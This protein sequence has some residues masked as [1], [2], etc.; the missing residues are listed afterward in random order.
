MYQFEAS[1]EMVRKMKAIIQETG[2]ISDP[3]ISYTYGIRARN[4]FR[5]QK[6]LEVVIV[7]CIVY[8]QDVGIGAYHGKE[9]VFLA[10]GQEETSW[11]AKKTFITKVVKDS[12]I[13][14]MYTSNH[15]EKI[16]I[17]G[18]YKEIV[19]AKDDDSLLIRF[20]EHL[21]LLKGSNK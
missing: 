1:E 8:Y 5:I 15:T 4:V 2:A 6:H 3:I 14:V 21:N 7:N 20:K 17:P 13:I 9:K 10:I 18:Y 11:Y 16:I 19:R 12:I